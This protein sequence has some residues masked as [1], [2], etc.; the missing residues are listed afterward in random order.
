MDLT[1]QEI[2]KVV[3]ELF[4]TEKE[5]MAEYR[6]EFEIDLRDHGLFTAVENLSVKLVA[7]G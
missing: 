5:V 3:S 4:G 2:Q 1:E 6:A 7:E